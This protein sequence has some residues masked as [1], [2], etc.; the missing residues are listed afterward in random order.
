MPPKKQATARSAKK[1]KPDKGIR[2]AV[3]QAGETVDAA[4][5]KQILD[6]E[7][8]DYGKVTKREINTLKSILKT[9]EFEGD[10]RKVIENFIKD[11]GN[12][13]PK[14]RNASRQV[15][16][17]A[18]K[19]VGGQARGG[20]DCKD[21]VHHVLYHAGSTSFYDWNRR[22]KQWD[23]KPESPW[24]AKANGAKPGN[25]V[26]ILNMEWKVEI[27]MRDPVDGKMKWKDRGQ[28]GTLGKH[29][30]IVLEAGPNH[31][32]IAGQNTPQSWKDIGTSPST[33]FL[34]LKPGEWVVEK[35]TRPYR[36]KIIKQGSFK[37]FKPVLAAPGKK[38]LSPTT[39][40]KNAIK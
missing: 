7:V 5:A 8:R 34:P 11:S 17:E 28:T 35:A 15:V 27:G 21:F 37:Y 2:D 1:G 3:K 22:K 13:K 25:I 23:I 12:A 30:G 4:E 14:G 40:A 18:R 10:G 20:G 26:V 29:V 6:E 33:L 38:A 9:A 32:V 39:E 24:G 16:A 36:Y 31:I 19:K